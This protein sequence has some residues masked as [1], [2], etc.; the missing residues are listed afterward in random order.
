MILKN[1]AGFFY[2]NSISFQCYF[3]SSYIYLFVSNYGIVIVPAL[4]TYTHTPSPQKRVV[5][6]T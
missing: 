6:V 5:V 1:I 4:V 2:F 3:N